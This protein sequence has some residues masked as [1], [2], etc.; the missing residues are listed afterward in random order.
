M[1]KTFRKVEYTTKEKIHL[2]EDNVSPEARAVIESALANTPLV[3]RVSIN[4]PVFIEAAALLT[5]DGITEVCKFD[6]RI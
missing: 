1:E 6:R 3:L 4:T 2:T 5:S